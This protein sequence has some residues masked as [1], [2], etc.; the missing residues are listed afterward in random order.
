MKE[1]DVRGSRPVP[2]YRR[3]LERVRSYPLWSLVGIGRCLTPTPEYERFERI[4]EV[5]GVPAAERIYCR[6][7]PADDFWS[8]SRARRRRT[9]RGGRRGRSLSRVLGS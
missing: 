6:P 7:E 4:S 1:P 3:A 8:N 2:Y 5:D 9:G